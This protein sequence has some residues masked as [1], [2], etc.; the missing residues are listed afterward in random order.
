MF[1]V[2]TG[3]GVCK[4][5]ES[6]LCSDVTSGNNACLAC[7]GANC[8]QQLKTC[9]ADYSCGAAFL[10]G[11]TSTGAAYAALNQ[12]LVTPCSSCFA[13]AGDDAGTD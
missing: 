11:S 6:S 12:C 1:N 7:A 9:G 8:C 3:T 2:G 4:P 13:S 5:V 10:G